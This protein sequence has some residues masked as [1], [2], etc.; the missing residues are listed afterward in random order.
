MSEVSTLLPV[1]RPSGS[2][3]PR[4]NELTERKMLV[5]ARQA[6]YELALVGATVLPQR[7]TIERTP[8]GTWVF[9][10]H[11]EDPTAVKVGV[12]LL[13]AEAESKIP[14][15]SDQLERLW[16]LRN[17][18][19]RPDLVWIAHQLPDNYKDGD[20]LP[21]L[22]PPPKQL[23]EKDQRL[24][25]GLKQTTKLFVQGVRE[26]ASITA[27]AAAGIASVGVG[28]DPIILGGVRHAEHAIVQWCVLAQWEWE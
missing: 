4:L 15:P 23:R 13:R 2:I 7:Q 1:P 16:A 20:P 8:Y 24:T 19:V 12:D 9:V 14:V 26:L 25:L 17:A 6:G 21:Q 28:L 22:V 3:E 10:D 18:G 5:P 11:M 27:T